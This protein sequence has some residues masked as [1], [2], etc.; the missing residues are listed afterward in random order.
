MCVCECW[1]CWEIVVDVDV[2]L[3]GT[4]VLWEEVICS[5]QKL[6]DLVVNS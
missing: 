1:G 5:G 2:F 3:F 4:F 6:V